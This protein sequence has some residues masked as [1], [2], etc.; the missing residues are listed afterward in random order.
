MGEP[1]FATRAIRISFR[2]RKDDSRGWH[3]LFILNGMKD[4]LCGRLIGIWPTETSV[5]RR[6]CTCSQD[7]GRFFGLNLY[8]FRAKLRAVAIKLI[9]AVVILSLCTFGCGS[10]STNSNPGPLAVVSINPA[11]GA[12]GVPL[13]ECPTVDSSG[14]PVGFCGGTVSVTFNRPVEAVTVNVSLKVMG[15]ADL[16]GGSM[17][18]TTPGNGTKYELCGPGIATT[19]T[20]L[21]VSSTNLT[22]GTVYQATLSPTIGDCCIADSNGNALSG[23]PVVWLFTTTVNA[24]TLIHGTGGRLSHANFQGVNNYGRVARALSLSFGCPVLDAFQGRGSWFARAGAVFPFTQEKIPVW[25]TSIPCVD[26]VR[27][28]KAKTPALALARTGH[29]TVL[30]RRPGHPPQCYD[31]RSMKLEVAQTLSFVEKLEKYIDESKFIP[32]TAAYRGTVVLSLLS[33]SLTVSRA[34]CALVESGFPEEAFG[35]TRTLID[36]YFTV[37]HIGNQETES[38]SER[39][40]LFF[41]KNHE[42]WSTIFPKYFPSLVIP[43]NAIHRFY[44]ETAR[45]YK[46]PNDWSGMRDGT[47]GLAL[48]P[49]NYEFEASGKPTTAEFDYEVIFKWTSHFVHATVSSLESHLVERGDAFRVRAR[50]MLSHRYAN[51]ALFNVLAFLSKIFVCAFRALNQEQPEVLLEIHQHMASYADQCAPKTQRAR[52]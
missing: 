52:A 7:L 2:H 38:R 33:K 17:E 43:D 41:A 51:N 12:T 3:R 29:P 40:A 21:F 26:A 6:C 10:Q 37:R 42:S 8:R 23:L 18:C 49:D 13:S 34:V 1:K 47:R 19:A 9:I 24:S 50:N 25:F 31:N 16:L 11:N 4:S 30:I 35:L 36:I 27:E 48:E 45:N 5:A 46:S 44:L 15:A 39:F 14:N 22:P 20:M 28:Y 32:A